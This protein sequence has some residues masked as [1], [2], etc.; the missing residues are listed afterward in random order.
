MSCGNEALVQA[1]LV[2]LP[3]ILGEIDE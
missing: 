2:A 1:E 3:Q